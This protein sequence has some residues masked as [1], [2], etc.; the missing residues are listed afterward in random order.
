MHETPVAPREDRL[1]PNVLGLVRAMRRDPATPQWPVARHRD[2]YET[3]MSARPL[4]AGVS[5]SQVSTPGGVAEWIRPTRARDTETIL[6]LHGG[7]FVM[8]SIVTARPIAADLAKR[9]GRP[10]LVLD[11]PLAPEATFPEQPHAAARTWAWLLEQ[12]GVIHDLVIAGDSAGGALAVST[13]LLLREQGHSLPAACVLLSPLLDLRMG[14]PTLDT[15]LA[16]DPQLPRWMLT[17]MCE[18]Y[19]GGVTDPADT[20]ASPVLADLRGLPR[21]LVQTAEL[22]ALRPDAELFTARCTDS[23]VDCSLQI[24]PGMIHVWHNFTPRLPEAADALQAV[25]NWLAE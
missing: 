6:Y 2:T 5:L 10:V 23:K 13:M 14:N 17:W 21:T 20:L 11:Y 19:L 3:A 24:W 7:G 12:V 1:S 25:A 18:S 16:D 8:G 22:E 15:A 4:P 9:T